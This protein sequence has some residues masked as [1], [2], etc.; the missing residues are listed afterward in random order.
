MVGVINQFLDNPINR[1]LDNFFDDAIDWLFNDLFDH[2]NLR[3]R[4]RALFPL[5]KLG[6]Q[7][8]GL[9]VFGT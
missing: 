7:L 9:G 3:L 4:R 8:T 1:L 5:V 2:S 6:P